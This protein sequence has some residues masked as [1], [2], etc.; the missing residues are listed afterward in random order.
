MS[1]IILDLRNE[2][3]VL[4]DK[5]SKI[6]DSCSHP[7]LCVTKKHGSSIGGYEINMDLYWTDFTCSLCEKRWR[8]EGSL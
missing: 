6:Q 3:R 7:S 2:I 1:S 4:E 5:I 8:E